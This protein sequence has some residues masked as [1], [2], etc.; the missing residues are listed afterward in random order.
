MYLSIYL[1]LSIYPSIYLSIH[2]PIYLST[3]L[4]IYLSLS[5]SIYLP[6]YLSLYLSLSIYLTIFLSNYLSLMCISIHLSIYLSTYL[7]IY[8]S[9]SLSLYL[10][11]YPSIYLSIYLSNYLS[12]YLSL[13]LSLYLSIDLSIYL[14]IYLSIHL[15]IYPS[16]HLSISLSLSACLPGCLSV[17]LSTCLSA[18]LKTKLF[19]ETSLSFEVD[20]IKNEAILRDFFI[21]WTGQHPK[22][23]NSARLLQFFN[24]T[25]SKTKQF[26]ETSFKNGKSWQPL[27]NAFRNFSNP[28]VESTAP[29]TKKWCQ[30]IW[31]AAP[32]TQNHLSKPTDLMLQNANPLRKSAPWLPNISDEHVSCAAPATEN[33]SLK[34][35]F[36]CPTPAIV[37]GNA[38]KPSRF[39]HFWEGAQSLAPATR[40]DILSSKSGRSP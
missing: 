17:C 35:L 2:L 6:I 15:S 24:L 10:S 32:V 25:T 27:T 13:Y 40:N 34:I 7:S 11:I 30:V 14:P 18:S 21:F 26:C 3:Y 33:A 9:I 29:A 39:A 16:I 5:L 20:N 38:T 1:S 4:P 23:S 8:L 22:R 28:P 31:S 12:I 37:F 19:F 36:K